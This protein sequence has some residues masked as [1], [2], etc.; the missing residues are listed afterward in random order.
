M[1]LPGQPAASR[2]RWR[3]GRHDARAALELRQ[4]RPRRSTSGESHGEAA[5]CRR[6]KPGARASSRSARKASSRLHAS[7]R[8]EAPACYCRRR[9]S[10]P[11]TR[12]TSMIQHAIGSSS[13]A[14]ARARASCSRPPTTRCSRCDATPARAGAARRSRTTSRPSTQRTPARAPLVAYA[15][16][17]AAADHRRP[18]R[19]TRRTPRRRASAGR[20]LGPRGRHVR[21]A[22]VR[23]RQRALL[24]CGRDGSDLLAIESDDGGRHWKT[25][26]GL[27]G[28]GGVNADPDAPMRQH[29]LRKGL[30]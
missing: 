28:Q 18:R 12:C 10:P 5:A 9:R 14:A 3:D 21:P 25:M 29:R 16:R 8:T 11:A 24:L 7:P 2:T 6:A 20:V 22:D 23:S 17:A 19:R 4:Q 26:S 27:Q 13:R 30:D 15:Q 1:L